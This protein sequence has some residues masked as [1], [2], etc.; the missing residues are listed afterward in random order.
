MHT[1]HLLK[2][3]LGLNPGFILDNLRESLEDDSVDDFLSGG[4]KQYY[5]YCPSQ[6]CTQPENKI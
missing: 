2:N 1:L 6:D 5:Y 4:Q 3:I